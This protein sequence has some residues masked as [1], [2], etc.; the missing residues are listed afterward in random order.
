MPLR[1]PR[2][3]LLV[4]CALAMFPPFC[5][6]MYLPAFASIAQ[7]YHCSVGAI[8][9]SLAIFLVGFAGAQ[10]VFGPLSDRFGRVRTL[11]VGL[12]LFIVCSAAAPFCSQLWGFDAL[13]LGQAVGAGSSAVISFAIIRDRFAVEERVKV[14]GLVSALMGLAPI[15]APTIGGLIVAHAHWTWIFAVLAILGVVSLLGVSVLAESAGAE[16]AE[17][18]SLAAFVGRTKGF[19]QHR[20][21]ILPILAGSCAFA[22]MFA[23]ISSSSAVYMG[24]FHLSPSVFGLAFAV[25]AAAF[26]VGN[27]LSAKLSRRLASAQLLS[28][29]VSIVV[30]GGLLLL[31]VSFWSWPLGWVMASLALA[32]LGVGITLPASVA[33]AMAKMT[34][35]FGHASS[36][37]AFLQ[38]GLATVMSVVTGSVV[39]SSALPLAV[40]VLVAGV[41]AAVAWSMA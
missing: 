14:V 1:H 32:T 11:Q 12:G 2:F 20:Q 37:I 13:R 10:L 31:A 26:M 18:F 3:L 25:N 15:I 6:D 36:L 22:A 5:T 17:R 41:L 39:F 8:Q 38:F 4:L 33:Y 7:S 21:F 16:V 24:V 27:G 19:I 34:S 35:H 23:F 28:I 9:V 40:L 29:G 30:A